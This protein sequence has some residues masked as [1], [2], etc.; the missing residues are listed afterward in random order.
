M[1][2]DGSGRTM[3]IAPRFA[4]IRWRANEE[5]ELAIVIADIMGWETIEVDE[6]LAGDFDPL[7]SEAKIITQAIAE[8]DLKSRI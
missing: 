3:R 6:L 8:F 4:A 1:L 2:R 7:P 5:P